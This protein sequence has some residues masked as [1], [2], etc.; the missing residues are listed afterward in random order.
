M[1]LR[2][3]AASAIVAVTMFAG[4][5][6]APAAYA[7]EYPNFNAWCHVSSNSRFK[8]TGTRPATYWYVW[9]TGY[10]V[11]GGGTVTLRPGKIFSVNTAAA[12]SPNATTSTRFGVQKK[13][14]TFAYLTCT[15]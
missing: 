13:D 8:N 10:T 1:K 7:T 11:L 15:S 2:V 6:A 9:R 14:G 3:K 5:A 12:T 4:L